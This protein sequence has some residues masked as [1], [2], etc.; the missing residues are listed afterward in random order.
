MQ[1]IENFESVL[2]IIENESEIKKHKEK[3]EVL[4]FIGNENIPTYIQQACVE[5]D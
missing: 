2:S 3:E 5:F 1:E 4:L